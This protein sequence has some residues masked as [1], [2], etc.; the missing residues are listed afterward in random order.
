M[1]AGSTARTCAGRQQEQ[2]MA[3]GGGSVSA[4][5][6]AVTSPLL[7]RSC[8]GDVLQQQAEMQHSL[9]DRAA[10]WRMVGAGWRVVWGG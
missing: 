10:R 3:A 7:A 1:V 4:S 8:P 6:H 2:E 5:A 9:F